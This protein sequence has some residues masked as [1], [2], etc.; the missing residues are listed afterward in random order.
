[1]S[2]DGVTEGPLLRKAEVHGI[3]KQLDLP[4]TLIFTGLFAEYVRLNLFVPGRCSL[5]S[6]VKGIDYIGSDV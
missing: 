2:T 4:Y 1:M 3:L 5:I 6:G